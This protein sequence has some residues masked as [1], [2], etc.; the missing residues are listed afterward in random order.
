MPY[1]RTLF[2]ALL[3]AGA[4]AVA[5]D[6][7]AH[8]QELVPEAD[9][10]PEGGAVTVELAFTHPMEG[11][12]AME[13]ARPARF[14]VLAG[15]ERTDLVDALVPRTVDG[16]QA[17]SARHAL[18]EPGAAV[19]Y[20]EPAPYFEPA[21]GKYI[22]HYTKAVVDSWASGVG[23]DAMV[24][25]PVEIAP[26]VRPTGL[27]TGNLFRGLVLKA[28]EPVPFAEVEVAFRNDGSVGIPNE[29]FVTQVIKADGDGVFSYAMPRAGWWGFAALTEADD[30]MTA[31]DGRE[32]PVEAGA[33][34]WVRATD[35]PAAD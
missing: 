9:V 29:A 18:P 32:V 4:A 13:M 25:F 30:T 22:V 34:M 6:A 17:F 31:P 33:L 7:R 10:L 16:R 8:F 21:E 1:L 26:L 14:G 27:W 15:G 12:P 24:G 5:G 19:F 35:M 28:G 11:G 23:W 2:A 3:A 20:V